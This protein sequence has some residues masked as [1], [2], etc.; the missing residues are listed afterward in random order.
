MKKIIITDLDGT[1]VKNSVTVDIYD[2][3]N[4]KRLS[5]DTLIAVATGRSIKEI[6][7]IENENNIKFDYKIGFN[8]AQIVDKNGIE[9][10][11]K[12]IEKEYLNKLYKFFKEHNLIFDALDGKRR[13]GN[14]NHDKPDTIW[15]MEM[16]IK[17]NPYDI[18]EGL[19]IYKINVRPEADRCQEIFEKLLDT[20]Q[21]LSIEKTSRTRIEIC[22][23][24]ITKGNAIKIITKNKDLYSIGI[25]D[26]END[27]SMFETVNY[28]ICMAHAPNSVKSICNLVVDS[29]S[30]I[31]NI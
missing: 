16:L 24:N 19:E 9:I 22:S 2:F 4:F 12:K 14:F 5:K 25:G 21:E 18:L 23:K 29:I 10:F 28:S 27:R 3:K 7:Y 17:D 1:F 20:F 8:G 26:S 15:N 6:E 30:K 11:S 13:I 31:E